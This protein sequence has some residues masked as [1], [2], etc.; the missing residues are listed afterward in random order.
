MKLVMFEDAWRGIVVP[1]IL[2]DDGVV[3][4]HS[5]LEAGTPSARMISLIDGFDGL[6]L[7]LRELAASADEHGTEAA[8]SLLQLRNQAVVPSC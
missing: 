5:I 1:G 3:T 8:T 2:L 6:R 7:R 4:L